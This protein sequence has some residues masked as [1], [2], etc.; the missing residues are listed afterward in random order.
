M[1]HERL[2]NT[3]QHLRRTF[4]ED[5]ADGLSDAQL[6]DRFLRQ[7]DQAAFELLVWRHQRMVLTVCRRVLDDV[8]D[9]EDAFQATFLILVRKADSIGRR[10]AVASWLYKVA[11]RCALRARTTRQNRP[12]QHGLDLGTAADRPAS[13]GD[14]SDVWPL[15][16]DELACLPE[17]YRAP[18]VLC[19]LEG[20]TYD[21]AAGQLAC[22]LG[23]VSTRLTKARELL[24]TRLARR[25]LTLSAGA[26][27]EL[28]AEQAAEA[29]VPAAL[30][31]STVRAALACAAG[32]SATAGLVPQQVAAL[33]EGVLQAMMWTKLKMVASVL[34]LGVVALAGGVLA[35]QR[36]V[37]PSDSGKGPAKA[38]AGEPAAPTDRDRL[39]GT[40]QAVSASVA[41]Q[42]IPDDRVRGCR[43]QFKGDIVSLTLDND[44]AEG[45]FILDISRKP[46][47]IDLELEGG[48]GG[49]GIY[50]LDGDT[51]TVCAADRPAHPRPTDFEAGAQ[52]VLL[53]FKRVP[54]DKVGEA[55]PARPRINREVALL[56]EELR[57]T[58]ALAEVERARSVE[59]QKEL[60][61]VKTEPAFILKKVD[62]V[63]NTVSVTLPG[64]TLSLEAIPISTHAKFTLD[65]KETRID[66]LKAGMRASLTFVVEEGKTLV[67]A[68]KATPQDPR[69]KGE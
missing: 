5:G 21:E 63:K 41:G 34:L 30:V 54:R 20:K 39:Q 46:K 13:S 18:F 6:L 61:R 8:H 40:W 56:K 64:T 66:D 25:G 52:R 62:I 28:L 7:R 11:Y 2:R 43:V 55:P 49:A 22:P 10:E 24:R 14:G 29:A 33:T 53:V 35:Q 9:A 1:A 31:G 44:L 27:G 57:A 42:K 37:D 19:Y 3:L 50:R 15:L 48:S 69:S 58:R 68:I 67:T 23:T 26:L 51:L 17:K 45:T 47:A 36:P 12:E 65:G 60:E 32:K 16:Q 4:D 59:L 38:V